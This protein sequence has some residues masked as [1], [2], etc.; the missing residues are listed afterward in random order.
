MRGIIG[1]IVIVA[2]VALGG[3]FALSI[4]SSVA[5]VILPNLSHSILHAPA[6]PLSFGIPRISGGLMM[7]L[8]HAALII[9][10]VVVV[11]KLVRRETPPAR[12]AS[13]EEEARLI[14]ELYHGFERLESRIESL[15][16]IIIDQRHRRTR[17][18][19]DW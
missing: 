6:A 18:N 9:G 14:Q 16:S 8:L 7:P 5:A 4:L 1:A 10:L 13:R 17:R 19:A 15:E 3:L 11:V 2:V 12:R